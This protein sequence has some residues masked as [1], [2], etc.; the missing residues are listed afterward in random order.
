MI[1]RLAV[2]W[3]IFP[4][5]PGVPRRINLG[6][7]GHAA[8][9]QHRR[10]ATLRHFYAVRVNLFPDNACQILPNLLPT[11]AFNC[12]EHRGERHGSGI[13]EIDQAHD[14]AAS[15]VGNGPTRR[16][17]DL[18]D[19]T[20]RRVPATL[21]AFATMCRVGSERSR[22]M[23]RVAAIRAHT[24]CATS[25][26]HATALSAGESA[27]SS[28]KSGID[29]GMRTGAYFWPAT[30]ASM[31]FDHSCIMCRRCTSYSALL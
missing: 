6:G 31:M 9:L 10:H 28:S 21:R 19:G 22:S 16:Q 7:D 1:R 18:R 4:A 30:Q 2:A 26:R 11:I 8:N 29:G 24:S 23:A 17:H 3:H 20:A 5:V 13:G 25:R 27:G 12:S 14:T 15:V